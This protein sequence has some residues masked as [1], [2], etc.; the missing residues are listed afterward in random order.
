MGFYEAMR[1]FKPSEFLKWINRYHWQSEELQALSQSPPKAVYTQTIDLSSARLD[2]D[3]LIVR[4]PGRAFVAYG[5]TTA[6]L[7]TTRTNAT[8][9]YLSARIGQNNPEFAF[10][11]KHNRGFRGDFLELYLSWPAQSGKSCDLVIHQFDDDP[12]EEDSSSVSGSS[13]SDP[14]TETHGGTGEVTYAKGDTLY[15]SAVDTISKLS[16]GSNG[17]ILAVQS[18]GVPGWE[19]VVNA[20]VRT[21]L[22]E[23]FL[24]GLSS[25][26]ILS[27]MVYGTNGG[28]GANASFANTVSSATNI[29]VADIE[30]GTTT[31]GYAW[32]NDQVLGA[33]GLYIGGGS[34][35]YETVVK[36]SN[37]S[38]GT[39]TFICQLGICTGSTT[40]NTV[41]GVY[42]GYSHSLSG[43]NW[44]CYTSRSSTDT[45]TD[46]GV[47]ASAT[48]F[49]RLG[50]VINAALSSVT[51]YINGT[52]VA[53]HAT[54]IP[55]STT[56]MRRW[57]I[58]AKSAGTTTRHLYT[59]Y[60]QHLVSYTTPR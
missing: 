16:I 32:I 50:F 59:D 10:P 23:D 24:N 55:L 48:S 49:Q 58:I 25:S 26:N 3:P 35:F 14:V 53:T 21:A 20:S 18:T 38:D 60:I 29:G 22:Y 44:R 27:S 11:V 41:D 36:L 42:F 56:A 33:K 13:L 30:T 52:L 31:T 43:G 40:I 37:L 8:D 54:N 5:F 19:N 9:I 4:C 45:V 47:A 6:T 7:N 2:S 51:F 1:F 34:H 46:S 57:A 28:A 12:W 15:A 17:Q 39:E